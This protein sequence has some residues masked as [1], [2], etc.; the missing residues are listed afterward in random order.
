MGEMIKSEKLGL[1]IDPEKLKPGAMMDRDE[2]EQM[3]TASQVKTEYHW[4]LMGLRTWIEA[5]AKRLGRPVVLRQR[6]GALLVCSDP[7]AS[8]YLHQR[9]EEGVLQCRHSYQRMEYVDEGK[10]SDPQKAQHHVRVLT[11]GEQLT[12]LEKT[13]TALGVEDRAAILMRQLHSG[14][15]LPTGMEGTE[16]ED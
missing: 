2:L 15:Q 9:F 10:L 4:W 12:V 6:N 13:R 14:V 16:H 7:D 5:E 8:D 3:Y 1:S 11:M